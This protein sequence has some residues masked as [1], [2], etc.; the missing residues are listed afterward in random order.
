MIDMNLSAAEEK[1]KI[2][3]S[4]HSNDMSFTS[5]LTIKTSLF[6]H[7]PDLVEDAFRFQ[8]VETCFNALFHV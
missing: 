8:G 4:D 6:W 2:F 5:C 3:S 1:Q 7:G